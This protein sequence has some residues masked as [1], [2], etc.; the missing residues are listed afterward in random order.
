MTNHAYEWDLL[1]RGRE[2]GLA[3]GKAEGIAQG[4]TEGLAL[5]KAE[6]IAQGRTEGIAQGRAEGIAQGKAEAAEKLGKLADALKADGKESLLYEAAKD[7]GLFDE[8]CR[9]YGIL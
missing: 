5:G 2:Q 6:G 8:L 9:R 4:R 7:A 1:E 3:L